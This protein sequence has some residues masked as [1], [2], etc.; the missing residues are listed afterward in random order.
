MHIMQRYTDAREEE[1]EERES[2]KEKQWK[3]K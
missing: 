3:N 2:S 1:E